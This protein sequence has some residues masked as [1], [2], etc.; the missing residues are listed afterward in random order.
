M[1]GGGQ[2]T[3]KNIWY[4]EADKDIF[5]KTREHVILIKSLLCYF[6]DSNKEIRIDN[7]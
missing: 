4:N 7:I 1:L 3:T 5:H 2:S 6:L